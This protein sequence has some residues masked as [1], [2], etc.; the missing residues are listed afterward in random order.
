M[1]V[2]VRVCEAFLFVIYEAG[3]GLTKQIDAMQR[4]KQH[5]CV[6]SCMSLYVK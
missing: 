3:Q 5:L 2:G 4:R 6:F 1:R